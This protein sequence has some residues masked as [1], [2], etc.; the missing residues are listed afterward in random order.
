MRL[1]LTANN[2]RP[3]LFFLAFLIPLYLTWT[4]DHS[5]WNPDETRDAGI[6]WNM[7]HA[8][9]YAV[10][11]LNGQA[12]L[13]KPP[14]YYWAANFIYE[15]TG[16]R[17]AGTTRLPSAL[18]GML[19]ALFT[20]LIGRRLFNERVGFFAGA[21]L[22]TSYQYFWM[23]HF[24]LMD[25]MLAALIA[26]AFYFHLKGSRLGF[27]L[28]TVLAF[29]AKGFLGVILTGTV[30]T[31]DLLVGRKPMELAK[32][33]GLGAVL[34]ALGVGPW[35][36]SLW[37]SGGTDYL[38]IFLIDNHWHRFATQTGDH[39]EHGWYFYFLSFWGD[40][41]PWSILFAGFLWSL[42]KKWSTIIAAR[43][44][45]FLMFWFFGMLAFF[46]LSSSKRSIYLL[47]LFPAAAL[48]CAVWLDGVLK[49][50]PNE[51]KLESRWLALFAGFSFLIIVSS[52]FLP[53]KLDK[54]KTFVPLCD[55]VKANVGSGTI[56]G[57]NLSEMERG[58][59]SFYFDRLLPNPV[60]LSQLDQFVKEKKGE[61]FML[62]INRRKLEEVQS[63]LQGQAKLFYEYRPDKPQR[64]YLVYTNR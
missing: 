25:V 33:I 5:L 29:Y 60:D 12:F 14:L 40:F 27:I 28:M 57:Y 56:A 38:K 53:R 24:A 32:V 4:F 23:S 61:T 43:P 42:R 9:D 52:F 35:F 31:I 58:V 41:L 2:S 51:L 22:A 46:T 1:T 50:N 6:A 37:K 49:G 17:T 21:L 47:P 7:H 34:F 20:Y 8:R 15:M 44:T 62:I 30:V 11:R 18:F 3:F 54:N 55:I 36:W 39:T 26:G 16:Q 48:L 59:F 19:G 10:P 45:R 63:T 13:E 64:S